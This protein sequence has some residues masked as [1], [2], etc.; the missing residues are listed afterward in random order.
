MEAWSPRSEVSVQNGG[1]EYNNTGQFKNGGLEY[2][3]RGQCK[4]GGCECTNR[5]GMNSYDSFGLK[6][7]TRETCCSHDQI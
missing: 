4:N 5:A 6:K 7:L 3:I 2:N 1:L